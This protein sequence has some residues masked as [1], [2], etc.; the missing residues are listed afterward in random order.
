MATALLIKAYHF[1][2]IT[3]TTA[4]KLAIIT[5]INNKH[6][7]LCLQTNLSIKTIGGWMEAHC[8]TLQLSIY[9]KYLLRWQQ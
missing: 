9:W 3:P 1:W 2:T 4:E 5:K 6:I 8:F 7:L